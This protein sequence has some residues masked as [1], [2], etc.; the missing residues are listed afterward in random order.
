MP[1]FS[2]QSAPHRLVKYLALK[3]TFA[4]VNR[5][6]QPSVQPARTAPTRTCRLHRIVPLAR[7]VRPVACQPWSIV[8]RASTVTRLVCLLQLGCVL[9]AIAAHKALALCKASPVLLARFARQA[10]QMPSH[11]RLDRSATS[12]GYRHLPA[13]AQ[14]AISALSELL[15]FQR[16]DAMPVIFALPAAQRERQFRARLDNIVHSLYLVRLSR[17]MPARTVPQQ[18]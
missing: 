3:A 18:G 16:M 7:S 11:A 15:V 1:V 5:A 6:P 9:E 17:A 4:H 14:M 13:T 8:R 10:L 2:A 12:L